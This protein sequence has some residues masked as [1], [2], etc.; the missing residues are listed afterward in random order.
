MVTEEAG[1][2]SRRDST[3]ILLEPGFFGTELLS[4]QSTQE[5]PDSIEDYA[6]RSAATVA[7]WQ[8]MDGKQG[9]DSAKLGAVLRPRG[10]RSPVRWRRQ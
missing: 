7:A 6:D 10:R 4:P 9:G 5:A 8:G 3:R 1:T 2:R